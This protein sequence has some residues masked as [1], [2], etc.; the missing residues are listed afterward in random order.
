MHQ[1]ISPIDKKYIFINFDLTFLSVIALYHLII[2]V[3]SINA[4]GLYHFCREIALSSLAVY[5]VHF[6]IFEIINIVKINF[7][8]NIM[9]VYLYSFIF[10]YSVSKMSNGISNYALT[11]FSANAN[12][13]NSI[14]A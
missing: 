1:Y 12:K 9:C 6:K 8:Y 7:H 5:T 11:K 13:Q 3:N 2:S 14:A 4:Y 10:A